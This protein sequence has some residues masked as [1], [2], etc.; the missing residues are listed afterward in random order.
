MGAD[1]TIRVNGRRINFEVKGTK[2]NRIAIYKL[3]VSSKDS[4]DLIKSGITVLR[5][6]R[7]DTESPLIA[8]LKYGKHFGLKKE[9]RWRF[10]K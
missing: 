6:I 10:T 3:K 7:T 2:D 8:E 5:V 9:P 1:I 4:H